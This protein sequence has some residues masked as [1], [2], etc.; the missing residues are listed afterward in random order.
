MKLFSSL[1]TRA[2]LLTALSFCSL[3]T[4]PAAFADQQAPYVC[5]ASHTGG[6]ITTGASAHFTISCPGAALGDVVQVSAGAD[7]LLLTNSAYVDSAG[8]VTVLINNV[9][10]GTITS[11]TTTY[12][13]VGRHVYIPPLIIN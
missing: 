11:P 2:A 1:F 8:S 12:V 7:S 4:I 5:S 3:A 10:A 9:S 13:V 6:A